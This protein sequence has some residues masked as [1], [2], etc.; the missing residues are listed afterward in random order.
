M[1]RGQEKHLGDWFTFSRPVM[2]SLIIYI[3]DDDNRRIV[4]DVAST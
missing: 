4:G 1:N 3:V 2:S